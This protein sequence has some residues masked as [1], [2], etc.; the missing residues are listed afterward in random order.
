MIG[1]LDAIGE[2]LVGEGGEVVACPVRYV[3]RWRLFVFGLDVGCLVERESVHDCEQEVLADYGELV[4][5]PAGAE[6]R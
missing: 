5:N 6:G 3:L 1:E 2:A 4:W